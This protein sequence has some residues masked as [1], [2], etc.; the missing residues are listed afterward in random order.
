MF[1]KPY[2]SLRMKKLCFLFLL[3]ILNAGQPLQIDVRLRVIDEGSV[4]I[5]VQVENHS[6]RSINHLEGFLSMVTD[7]GKQLAEKRLIIIGP[8][9]HALHHKRT[10]SKNIK[11]DLVDPFPSYKFNVSK[12]TF[13]GDYK[14][15]MYHPEIGFYRID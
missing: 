3:A 7:D 13:S 1:P 15:Y 4:N 9:D 8:N 12:I 5:V 6:K 11:M 10:V 14:I 2:R